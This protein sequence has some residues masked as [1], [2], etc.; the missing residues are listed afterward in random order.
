MYHEETETQVAKHYANDLHHIEPDK[1]NPTT[2]TFVVRFL[3][4]LAFGC[5][6]TSVKLI[7]PILAPP[8]LIIPLDFGPPGT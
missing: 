8:P 6:C 2:S 3:F 4:A 1:H 5:C 7:P